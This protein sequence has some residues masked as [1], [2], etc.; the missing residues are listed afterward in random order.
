MKEKYTQL[1]TCIDVRV[2]KLTIYISRREYSF[3]QTYHAL[4]KEQTWIR[5]S[6]VYR[7]T[8]VIQVLLFYH[9]GA[10]IVSLI[11]SGDNGANAT[12]DTPEQIFD[13]I[14]TVQRESP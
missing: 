4:A 11:Q 13:L 12:L 8:V 9:L 1:H 5:L 14:E 2:N 10:M 3:G 6:Q 7:G